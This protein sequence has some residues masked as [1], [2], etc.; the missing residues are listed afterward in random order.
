MKRI[1]QWH[2]DLLGKTADRLG[3][4]AYQIIWVAFAK[5]MAM[6]YIIG[7]VT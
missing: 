4:S 2:K 6:G 5:G 7:V 3:L 1:T